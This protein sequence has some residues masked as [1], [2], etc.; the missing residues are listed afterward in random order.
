MVTYGTFT[1][2]AYNSIIS[3]EVYYYKSTSATQLSGGSWSTTKPT[4]ENGK[5]VWQKIR[6]IYEDSSFSESDPVNITGQQGSNGSS[7]TSYKLTSNYSMIVKN[8]DG[9]YSTSSV[10][11]SAYSKTGTNSFSNYQGRFIIEVTTDNSTWNTVYTSSSNESSITY[12]ITNNIKE[13]RCSLYQSNGT[14]VLL[15]RMTIPIVSNGVGISSIQKY[16]KSSATQPAQP[17]DATI[18]TWNTVEPTYIPGSTDNIYSVEK[19]TYADGATVYS[20]V[21]LSASFIAARQAYDLASTT[22]DKITA[23]YGTCS[24]AANTNIKTVVCSNFTLYKG[25][26]IQIYF[27][28]ANS[29]L[30][31]TLNV[32][33]TGNKSIYI[34][35]TVIDSTNRLMW[36]AGSKLDFVYDDVGWVLQNAPFGLYGTCST[37]GSVSVKD[38]L[39]NE[40][41]ICKG[42]SISILMNNINAVSTPSLNVGSTATCLIKTNNADMTADS[43]YNWK[44]NSIQNFIF[45][46]QYWVMDDDTAKLNAEEAKK[47]ATNYLSSDNT[48]IMVADMSSGQQYV[49]STVPSGIKNTFIDQDSFNVRDGQEVLA[50]FGPICRIG[51]AKNF[52]IQID[53]TGLLLK[54]LFDDTVC[55]IGLVETEAIETYEEWTWPWWGGYVPEPNIA[56]YHFPHNLTE[57]CTITAVYK[58][59]GSA[60][61]T[62]SAPSDEPYHETVP[63]VGEIIYNGHG[64]VEIYGMEAGTRITFT[65][66][67]DA[68]KSS[69]IILGSLWGSSTIG[70]KSVSIGVNNDVRHGSALAVGRAV[71][72]A[73]DMQVVFGHANTSEDNHALEIGNGI[74]TTLS[75]AP[76]DALSNAFAVSW[77]GDVEMALDVNASAS[78]LDGKLYAEIEALGLEGE[79]II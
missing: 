71:K 76:S 3:T 72:T 21:S 13:I 57:G 22:N 26:R 20:P 42:T 56:H 61:I 69:G 35:K 27:E 6:T 54:S 49:P 75:D 8:E 50:S 67:V 51:N 41:V 11:F 25:V 4:W 79:V 28:N 14:T 34:N 10:I 31:P 65:Y 64:Y 15:D 73:C 9:T 78:T 37:N 44:A 24:T 47:T 77:D 29:A 62:I 63:G 60:P 16:Y 74:S 45:D 70:D 52:H 39:C 7:A 5:Y 58:P 43:I 1:I 33:S 23:V 66:T 17:T 46:G 19:I 55:K 36:T 68:I 38:V 18:S 40:A 2:T 53:N 48:G 12:T 30:A 32:N 59:P